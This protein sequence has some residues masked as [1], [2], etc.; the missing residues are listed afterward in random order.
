MKQ[1]S[2]HLLH[3]LTVALLMA[4]LCSSSFAAT[5]QAELEALRQEVNQLKQMVQQLSSA[6][7]STGSSAASATAANTALA[8]SV[9]Q[10]ASASIAPA[11]SAEAGQPMPEVPV[12][13]NKQGWAM[14]PD[15]KTAAKLYGF[16]RADMLH[17]FKGQPSGKFSNLHTQPLDSSDPVE[18]KTAF[19]AAVTRVGVD[20]KT[21]TVIGDVGGKI[22]GDFWGNGGTG[23]A[24]FRIRHAYLTTGNWLFGQ[25]WSPF[26]GQ[27]YAAETVDFNGV[28]GSSIRRAPQIRYTHPLNDATALTIAGE[29]DS[30]VD[31]R[32]PALTARLEHKRADNR[33]AFALRGMLH[34]KRGIATITED[35]KTRNTGREDEKTGYGAAIGA[36]YQLDP[37]NKLTGQFFHVKGDGAFNYGTGTGFSVNAATGNVYFDEYNSAQLGLTHSFDAKLRSTLALSWVDFKDSSHYA[38]A[39]PA[40]N[41]TLKQASINVFYKPVASIDLGTEY[42]YGTREVFNGDEGKQSHLNLMARYNF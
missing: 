10:P 17:D 28:A 29:E 20:F 12:A 38:Q 40:A 14:L 13:S 7:Q 36:W 42:T 34:E 39:N 30:S 18:N 37:A 22:E 6:Q 23:A 24:T 21:P 3:Q 26:A 8:A 4:G 2:P 41:K 35:G 19:T 16:I 11:Q 33:G 31:A 15:G 27:E 25:T 5:D 32:F 9:V 1:S